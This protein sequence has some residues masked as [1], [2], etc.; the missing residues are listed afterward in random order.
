[1]TLTVLTDTQIRLLLE[2]LTSSD[3]RSFRD[4]LRAALHAY[5]TGTQK[6]TGWKSIHQ[7]ERTTIRNE[8]AGTNTL[9]MPSAGPTGL[10]C[11]GISPPPYPPISPHSS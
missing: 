9:F 4:D 8:T 2:N 3:L 6:S 10:G 11:K 1:M 7:P 5:S